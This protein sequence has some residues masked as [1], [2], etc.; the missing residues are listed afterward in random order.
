MVLTHVS[1]DQEVNIHLASSIVPE[2]VERSVSEHDVMSLDAY[3]TIAEFQERFKSLLPDGNGASM[4]QDP[5]WNNFTIPQHCVENLKR[6]YNTGH[7]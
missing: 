2:N 1:A 6:K 5:I 3:M 4:S 7:P